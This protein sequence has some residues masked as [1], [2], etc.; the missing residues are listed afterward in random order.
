VASLSCHPCSFAVSL[1]VM[2][3][4]LATGGG[5]SACSGKQFENLIDKTSKLQ[6]DRRSIESALIVAVTRLR[7]YGSGHIRA[8]GWKQCGLAEV[9]NE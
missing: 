8:V 1:A 2:S 4:N 3:A 7:H 6:L 5:G 9:H